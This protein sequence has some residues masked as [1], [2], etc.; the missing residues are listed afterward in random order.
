MQRPAQ[1]SVASTAAK[2]NVCQPWLALLHSVM[3][4]R[5]QN[6]QLPVFVSDDAVTTAPRADSCDKFGGLGKERVR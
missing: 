3:S 6:W 2:A 5:I 1:A 4:Q